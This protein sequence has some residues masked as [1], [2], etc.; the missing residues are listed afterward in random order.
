MALRFAQSEPER[1]S[2]PS[3]GDGVPLAA[4]GSVP[5]PRATA[6]LAAG[7]SVPFAA[8]CDPD[9]NPPATI[10]PVRN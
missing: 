1:Q 7:G 5:L 3:R 8:G 2:S 4:G 10:I 6:S 9:P